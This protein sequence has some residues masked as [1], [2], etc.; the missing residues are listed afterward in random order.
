MTDGFWRRWKILPVCD[1][2]KDARAEC[3]T[4]DMMWCPT[5]K[6]AGAPCNGLAVCT[7]CAQV[8]DSSF[9]GE[10]RAYCPRCFNVPR[11]PIQHLHKCIKCFVCPVCGAPAFIKAAN[12]S[13]TSSQTEA[14]K[15]DEGQQQSSA[16]TQQCRISAMCVRCQWNS[17]ISATAPTQQMAF[18]AF[19][20]QALNSELQA[21]TTDK[22]FLAL[23]DLLKQNTPSLD[24]PVDSS[25]TSGN[26]EGEHSV[27]MESVDIGSN[28]SDSISTSS[29][30]T[31]AFAAG[32]TG[33]LPLSLLLP[34]RRSQRPMISLEELDK[35][36]EEKAQS[37]RMRNADPIP[38]PVVKSPSQPFAD[39]KVPYGLLLL[40]F[41][42]C[43]RCFHFDSCF[44][45][46][47]VDLNASSFGF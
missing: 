47:C 5:C 26:Q 8:V 6:G 19:C 42:L 11:S 16:Q 37:L 40:L 17:S 44:Y 20:Q 29:S 34:V 7:H 36:L 1:V 18:I 13:G 22:S 23:V 31:S 45:C 2:C 28:S 35:K 4:E 25:L 43:K 3:G 27:I 10:L 33:G 21:T 30:F 32:S 41:S 12:V 38:A 46:A 15:A 39:G 14:N 24:T 9:N